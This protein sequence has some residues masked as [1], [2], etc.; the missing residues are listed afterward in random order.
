[1]C[2]EK[3]LI[4]GIPK[5]S[6]GSPPRVR[7]KVRF[8]CFA[9]RLPRITPACAGK[10][11]PPLLHQKMDGDHPR[12]CGE[13][14]ERRGSGENIRGS[15]PRVRGKGIAPEIWSAMPRI[16]PACAGKSIGVV[17]YHGCLWDHPRVCG[18]KDTKICIFRIRIGSPPRVR[19]KGNQKGD[20]TEMT[21]ITPACAGKRSAAQSTGCGTRDHPR[22]CGE[23]PTIPPPPLQS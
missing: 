14:R 8:P 17:F 15:P 18:E 1:M 13:K 5:G 19:G 22:V 10:S 21:R 11:Q 2:G 7:G 4:G 20:G 9:D 16:T 23:K 12:V 3:S 6:R